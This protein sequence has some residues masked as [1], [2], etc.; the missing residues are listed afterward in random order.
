MLFGPQA[1]NVQP[2]WDL[3]ES[4]WAQMRPLLERLLAAPRAPRARRRVPAAPGVYL[5]SDGERYRYVGQTRDLR[6]RLGQHTRPSGTHNSATLAFLIAV[7]EATLSG[8]D[9]QRSRAKLQ[10]DP[11]F[12]EHFGR[13]KETVASWDVQYIEL[14]EPN[15]RTLFEV[16]VHQALRTDLNSFQ[17][18]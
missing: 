2:E 4:S 1:V 9:V 6:R 3:P 5:F 15:V 14:N 18:H 10:A 11:V 17:T 7:E 8:L 13:A 16:Y 12:A